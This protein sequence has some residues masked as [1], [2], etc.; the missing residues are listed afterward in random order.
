MTSDQAR[1]LLDVLTATIEREAKG[2]V[3]VLAA[4]PDNNHGYKPDAKSRTVWELATHLALNDIWFADAVLNGAFVWS[5][6]PQA[7]PEMTSAKAVA[8][9]YERTLRDRIAKLR[10]MS[11]EHTVRT[12]DFFGMKAPAVTWLL[13]MNNHSVHHRG[14]LTAY[15]RAAGSKVPAIYG[16]SADENLVGA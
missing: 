13:M 5:G 3:R 12:I 16:M 8:E 6:E 1:V 4:V 2:T 15:L 10:V 7:P 9:W 14:Q 11:P